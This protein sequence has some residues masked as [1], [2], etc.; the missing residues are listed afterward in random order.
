[1]L[2][3]YRFVPQHSGALDTIEYGLG[4]VYWSSWAIAG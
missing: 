4:A 1:M 3:G 2:P